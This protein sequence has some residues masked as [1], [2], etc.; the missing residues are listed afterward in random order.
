ME[1]PAADSAGS[2]AQAKSGAFKNI[3]M[4][5]FACC[6]HVL[7]SS[8]LVTGNSCPRCDSAGEVSELYIWC[9]KASTGWRFPGD[10]HESTRLRGNEL[11]DKGTAPKHAVQQPGVLFAAARSSSTGSYQ[12]LSW[13]LEEATRK[14]PASSHCLVRPRPALKA[15]S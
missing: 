5:S 9:R 8:S 1:I 3:L 2:T 14:I 12:A 15:C 11:R 13:V 10:W 4:C 6:W 7:E